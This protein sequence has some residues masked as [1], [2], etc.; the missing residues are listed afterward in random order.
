M[1]AIP[2]AKIREDVDE[3][4]LHFVDTPAFL[5]RLEALFSS[6]ANYAYKPASELPKLRGVSFFNS[7]PLLSSQVLLQTRPLLEVDP[8]HTD[9][10]L[11]A[12]WNSKHYEFKLLA[13][14]LLRTLSAKHPDEA[15]ERLNSWLTPD[16]HAYFKQQL[17]T[18]GAESLV[19]NHSDK[20]LAQV[21]T[22]LNSDKL[23]DQKTGMLA[24]TS[25][26]QNV[27]FENLP[28]IFTAITRLVLLTNQNTFFE[29]LDLLSAL[30]H[31]APAETA[32]FIRQIIGLGL[33]EQSARLLRKTI[34]A[35]PEAD[36]PRLRK[37]LAGY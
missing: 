6:Y 33:T 25:L 22:W 29:L 16:L 15:L 17:F 13:V 19:I 2:L 24:A 32:Y 8:A 12:L 5:T 14:H 20:W 3:V 37:L 30:A 35:F 9:A 18:T 36:Q 7:P 34:S 23:D 11:T 28:P 10:I 21:K 27:T 4:C 31:R 26:A 1:P